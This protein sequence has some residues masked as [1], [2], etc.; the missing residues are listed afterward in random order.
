MARAARVPPVVDLDGHLTPWAE[1]VLV[2]YARALIRND[3][4]TAR[5]IEK[6]YASTRETEPIH[7]VMDDMHLSPG[8]VALYGGKV[9]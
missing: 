8:L 9:L 4:K 6:R 1:T 7:D 3:R 5:E 2:E